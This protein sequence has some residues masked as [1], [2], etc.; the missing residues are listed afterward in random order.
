[1]L[2]CMA[3]VPTLDVGLGS[4]RPETGNSL[5]HRRSAARRRGS[6][7]RCPSEPNLA[8]GTVLRFGAKHTL[9]TNHP[10]TERRCVAWLVDMVFE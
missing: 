9:S 4:R 8:Q 2:L 10:K 7:G 5:R 6:H 1:M 3:A